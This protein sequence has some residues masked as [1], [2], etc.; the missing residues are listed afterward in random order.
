MIPRGDTEI[1]IDAVLPFLRE[2]P[3]ARVLDL[4][5]GSGCIAVTLACEAEDAKVQAVELSSEAFSY[6]QKNNRLYGEKVV[7]IQGDAL[8]PQTAPGKFDLIVSNPPYLSDG[9]MAVLQKEVSFEPAMALS[10]KEDGLYFYRELTRLY[11]SRL[12][13]NGMLAYEIGERQRQSV[14]NILEENGFHQIQ[15][16]YDY[17][18]LSRVITAKKKG[19]R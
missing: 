6:L 4:C 12:A 3:G 11:K 18:N 8:D 5:S 10:G 7:L 17:G 19:N 2:H 15:C 13:E 9:E 1:L 16:Y 14:I